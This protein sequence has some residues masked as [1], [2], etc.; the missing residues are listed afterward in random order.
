MTPEEPEAIETE[1]ES[2]QSNEIQGQQ[3]EPEIR[4]LPRRTRR[5]PSRFK[6]YIMDLGR[7]RT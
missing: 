7:N 6:D 2:D 4:E 5:L 3:Q 1:N